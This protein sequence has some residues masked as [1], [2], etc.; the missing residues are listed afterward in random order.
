MTLGY[1]FGLSLA[2]ILL[3]A[4]VII[5]IFVDKHH[6]KKDAIPFFVFGLILFVLIGAGILACVTETDAFSSKSISW[7]E[8][9]I[10]KL[11]QKI[12]NSNKEYDI[13]R[14]QTKIQKWEKNKEYYFNQIKENSE[15]LH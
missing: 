8:Y 10:S 2:F 4:L 6:G 7:A 11:E 3:I 1:I 13:I 15:N 12:E 14:Y 5:T 9:N